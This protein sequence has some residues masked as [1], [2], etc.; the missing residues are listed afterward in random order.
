MKSTVPSR[1]KDLDVFS[2]RHTTQLNKKLL[3]EA[4]VYLKL[5]EIDCDRK[6]AICFAK[7]R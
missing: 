4:L 3:S 1:D 5:R 2:E 6:Q 7:R